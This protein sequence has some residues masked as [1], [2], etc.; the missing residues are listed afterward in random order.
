MKINPFCDKYFTKSKNIAKI[1]GLNPI[2]EY[3]VFTR[4]DGVAAFE[5]M[6][7]M[8][9][10]LSKD[11]E[12][13][14]EFLLTGEEFKAKDTIAIIRG[15]FQDLVE[16]E[17]LYL[18]WAALPAYCAKEA[19]RITQAGKGKIISDFAARHLFDP[20]STALASYGAKIGGIPSA[21]TDVGGNAELWLDYELESLSN[22]LDQDQVFFPEL[23][24]GTTPHALLAIFNGDY[25][26]MADAYVKAYPNDKFV[27]LIDYNN[28]EIEDSLKVLA[29]HGKQLAGVRID[30][31]GENHA[32]IG[33]GRKGESLF[34]SQTGV[35][36]EAVKAL[37]NALNSH[38]GSHVKL[39]VSSG[40]DSNKV[41]DFMEAAGDSFDGIGTGSFI[42]KVPTAT[43]DIF[44]V[45]G[46][47][48]TKKGREWGLIANEE[49]KDKKRILFSNLDE[50]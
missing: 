29:A 50:Q 46:K 31:C 11:P 6:A 48:E 34:A 15:R 9:M 23:G 49:F 18:Q 19:R 24:M 37:R 39:F 42:P 40:F 5:P 14:V 38:D 30:T 47:T 2:V 33:I 45:D 4:F 21:S 20:T 41:A 7:N 1:A 3:R 17:T 28:Q 36:I 22:F 25:L 32:Q 26:A 43:A 44:S 35:T 8:I 13:S 12:T 27:A 16:L 10:E